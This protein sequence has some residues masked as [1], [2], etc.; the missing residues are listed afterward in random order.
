MPANVV[1]TRRLVLPVHYP[2]GIRAGR[3]EGSPQGAQRVTGNPLKI[4]AVSD[5]VQ[6]SRGPRLQSRPLPASRTG[7]LFSDVPI[8]TFRRQGRSLR[9]SHRRGRQLSSLLEKDSR[10]LLSSHVFWELSRIS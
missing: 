8:G 7:G 2:I 9:S 6:A 5:V 10:W 4:S 3:G 1:R